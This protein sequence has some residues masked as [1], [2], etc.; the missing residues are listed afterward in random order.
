MLRLSLSLHFF[1]PEFLPIKE[2]QSLLS[3][4]PKEFKE[5]QE[6][7][8]V[9]PTGTVPLSALAFCFSFLAHNVHADPRTHASFSSLPLAAVRAALGPRTLLLDRWQ[10]LALALAWHA[11]R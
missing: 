1:A 6:I 10:P 9:K 3:F 8:P 11:R 7:R 2:A 4:L 5:K